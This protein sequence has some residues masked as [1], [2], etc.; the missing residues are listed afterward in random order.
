LRPLRIPQSVD[1]FAIGAAK[2]GNRPPGG[3][4]GDRRLALENAGHGV[5]ASQMRS[6]AHCRPAVGNLPWQTCRRT[7]AFLCVLCG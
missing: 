3:C 2:V 4:V 7:G 1:T 5:F 6:T